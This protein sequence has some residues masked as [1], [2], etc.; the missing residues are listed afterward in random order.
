MVFEVFE[1]EQFER[2]AGFAPLG[3][4]VG[5]VRDGA[6]VGW[7]RRGN[8]SWRREPS[9]LSLPLHVRTGT[10]LTLLTLCATRVVWHRP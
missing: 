3:V 2:D 6:I 7:V 10:L 8:A 1:V 4:Q 5:A 9:R